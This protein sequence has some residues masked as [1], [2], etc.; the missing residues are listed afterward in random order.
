MTSP[1]SE[2]HLQTFCTSLRYTCPQVCRESERK[3]LTGHQGMDSQGAFQ[4]RCPSPSTTALSSPGYP[5]ASCTI[6]TSLFL[7]LTSP[8]FE[9]SECLRQSAFIILNPEFQSTWWLW[10]AWA[11]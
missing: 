5:S 11:S 1:C 4:K 7:F 9:R 10:R 6:R 3:L 2:I 8:D